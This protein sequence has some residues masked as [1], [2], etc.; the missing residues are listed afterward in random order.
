MELHQIMPVWFQTVPGMYFQLCCPNVMLKR[1]VRC[2]SLPGCSATLVRSKFRRIST[3]FSCAVRLENVEGHL[4]HLEIHYLL[5]SWEASFRIVFLVILVVIEGI[6]AIILV[7]IKI[8]SKDL[9]DGSGD[10]PEENDEQW[11]KIPEQHISAPK[12]SQPAKITR[13]D[14]WVAREHGPM[15]NND[16]RYGVLLFKLMNVVCLGNKEK[17]LLCVVLSVSLA[18]ILLLVACI[19]QQFCGGS[20]KDERVRYS[21]ERSQL[22]AKSNPCKCEAQSHRETNNELLSWEERGE[23]KKKRTLLFLKINHSLSSREAIT[24]ACNMR[25]R[26]LLNNSFFSRGFFFV[27]CTISRSDFNVPPMGADDWNQ[28]VHSE[29]D[30]IPLHLRLLLVH[31]RLQLNLQLHLFFRFHLPHTLYPL[32]PIADREK[33]PVVQTLPGIIVP[34][35][36]QQLHFSA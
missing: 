4:S 6:K 13:E 7:K 30:R 23:L 28:S 31:Y 2:Q 36:L 27:P 9:Q 8:T 3:Y 32:A 11:D 10:G 18:L 5:P 15:F 12:F 25:M 24:I 16:G 33:R 20:K 1:D 14:Q 34:P 19:V 22:I 21:I 35:W 17:V 29:W 26:L